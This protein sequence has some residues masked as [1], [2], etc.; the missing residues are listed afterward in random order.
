MRYYTNPDGTA[1]RRTTVRV[2]AL[3]G[4]FYVVT[5]VYGVLGRVYLPVLAPGTAPTRSCC[6][7]RARSSPAAEPRS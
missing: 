6:G 7:C 3:L 5:V 4:A 1:A 2:L